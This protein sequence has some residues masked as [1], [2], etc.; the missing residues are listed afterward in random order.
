MNNICDDMTGVCECKPGVTGVTCDRC[1]DFHYNFQESGCTY[2][3]LSN[4]SD[5]II[6]CSLQCTATIL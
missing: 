3:N 6:E 1:E 4:T 2:V 5:I